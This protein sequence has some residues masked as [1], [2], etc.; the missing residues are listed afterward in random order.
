MRGLLD[1]ECSVCMYCKPYARSMGKSLRR[2]LYA[3]VLAR[4]EGGF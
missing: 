1:C 4:I 2:G 3:R